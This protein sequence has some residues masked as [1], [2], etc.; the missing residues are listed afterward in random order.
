[1]QKRM[2]TSDYFAHIEITSNVGEMFKILF[3]SARGL[4][5]ACLT[6]VNKTF[7]RTRDSFCIQ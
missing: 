5:L 1:M 2:F 6:S 3:P 7:P 4:F